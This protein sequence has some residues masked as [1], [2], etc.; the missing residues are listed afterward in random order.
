MPPP[1]RTPA[2]I[3]IGLH[4][5]FSETIAYIFAADSVRLSSFT[6][7]Q[8][9]PKDASFLQQSVYWPFK[10]VRGTPRSIILARMRL[11]IS[12]SLWPWSYILH[13]F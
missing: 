1:R 4:L 6:F 3:R 12:P 8:W 10:V 13:R 7:V 11:P 5:I 2:N 9:A